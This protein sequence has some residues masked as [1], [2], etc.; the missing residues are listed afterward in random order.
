MSTFVNEEAFHLGKG[1]V[2]I[3]EKTIGSMISKLLTVAQFEKIEIK[4]I[5]DPWPGYIL[6]V[7]M[8]DDQKEFSWNIMSSQLD[9]TENP[10]TNSELYF[11]GFLALY[12]AA[13]R[14]GRI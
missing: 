8:D 9:Y 10:D 4:K 1:I 2:D 3:A 14:D 6:R 11:Q 12:E 7:Y 5:Q 13:L